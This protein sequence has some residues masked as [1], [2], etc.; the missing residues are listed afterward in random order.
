MN[1]GISFSDGVMIVCSRR[2]SAAPKRKMCGCFI[3][4]LRM[5]SLSPQ[6]KKNVLLDSAHFFSRLD[7]GSSRIVYDE[8]SGSSNRNP[9]VCPDGDQAGGEWHTGQR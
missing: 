5:W 3:S 4:V 1:M 7:D 2:F 8:P 6:E 9:S